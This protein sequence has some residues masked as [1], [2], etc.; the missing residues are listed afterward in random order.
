MPNTLYTFFYLLISGKRA[1]IR[2]IW[3]EIK[4]IWR[5]RRVQQFINPLFNLRTLFKNHMKRK[6]LISLILI[7]GKSCRS[8]RMWNYCC[9]FARNVC[10]MRPFEYFW[11]T[12]ILFAVFE[13]SGQKWAKYILENP[14][15]YFFLKLML[16]M[17]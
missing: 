13:L 9:G 6:I 1:S 2:N 10:K 8:D 15:M 16:A 4:P 3:K 12:V 17:L 14:K 11:T 7:L 5:G